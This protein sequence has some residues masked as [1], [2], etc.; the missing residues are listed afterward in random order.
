[1]VLSS[2]AAEVT[3]TS[4]FARASSNKFVDIQASREFGFTLRQVR[5]MTRTYSQMH[6]TDK[7]SQQSSIIW[8]V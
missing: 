6:R 7:Y 3:S 5:D 8:P 2:N 1:M 4:D